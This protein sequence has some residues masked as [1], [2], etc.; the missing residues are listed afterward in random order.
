MEI[1]LGRRGTPFEVAGIVRTLSGPA[2]AYMTG[3]T[4]DID[5]GVVKTA[6]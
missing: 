2:G 1:P 3:Q 6:V 4:L 5:G